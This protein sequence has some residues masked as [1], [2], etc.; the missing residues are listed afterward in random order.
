MGAQVL[1]PAGGM[2]LTGAVVARVTEET[3]RALL[4]AARRGDRQALERLLMRHRDRI[5]RFGMRMCGHPEDAEDVLQETMLTA[6]RSLDQFQGKSAFSSWL[7]AIARSFCHRQRRKARPTTSLDAVGERLPSSEEPLPPSGSDPEAI[8]EA[9]QRLDIVQEALGGLDPAHREVL[10]LRDVEGLSAREAASVLQIGVP[11]LKS[12]LHRAR[13]ALRQAVAERTAERLPEAPWPQS[14]PDIVDVY[15]RYLEQDVTPQ[16]C[17]AMEEH[18]A[19][20]PR[21]EA[22]CSSFKQTLRMCHMASGAEEVPVHV[23]LQVRRA[24]RDLLARSASPG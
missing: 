10:L 3:D 15:S 1:A 14:C 19:H 13:K 21:C 22:L 4:D 6:A 11:A 8:V 24:L 20:C 16:L 5:Y 23:Q 7:Y 18:I 12:R 17:R 2:R 9:R